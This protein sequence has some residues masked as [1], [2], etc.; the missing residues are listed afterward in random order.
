[1]E[2]YTPYK[3]FTILD[4]DGVEA[5]FVVNQVYEV[6]DSYLKKSIKEIGVN[7]EL[8]TD[9]PNKINRLYRVQL[10]L[11]AEKLPSMGYQTYYFKEI[12]DE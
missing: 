9:W 4:A 11:C 2:L 7:N 8:E 12:G 1:M 3:R 5:K 6:T 10:M